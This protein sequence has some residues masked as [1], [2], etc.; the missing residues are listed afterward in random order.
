MKIDDAVKLSANCLNLAEIVFDKMQQ[1]VTNDNL[2]SIKG[3]LVFSQS[4]V[5]FLCEIKKLKFVIIKTLS[6]E[7]K[8]AFILNIYQTMYIHFLIKNMMAEDTNHNGQN[9]GFLESFKSLFR[10]INSNIN[11]TYEISDQCVSLYEMK[12]IIIRRNKKPLNSYFRLVNDSDLRIQFIEEDDSMLIKLHIVCL[13]PNMGTNTEPSREIEH[14][15]TH[16]EASTVYEKLDQHCKNWLEKNVEE[17]EEDNIIYIPKL[18]KD[19][20]MDFGNTEEEMVK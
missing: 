12:N 8:L 20:I 5:S 18:F 3:D 19:Y 9:G 7:E 6:K 1:A 10:N 2:E 13:D 17:L 4:W 14:I 16:F 15:F 11:I